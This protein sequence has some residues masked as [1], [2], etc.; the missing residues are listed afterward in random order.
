MTTDSA[1]VVP[2]V[3]PNADHADPPRHLRLRAAVLAK[4][5]PQSMRSTRFWVTR[6]RDTFRFQ[7]SGYGHGVGLCQT[8]AL[9]RARSEADRLRRYLAVSLHPT[10]PHDAAYPSVLWNALLALLY[11]TLAFGLG[12]LVY[13]ATSD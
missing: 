7:G 12:T 8:G 13:Y 2:A 6:E 4:Y 10:L 3:A 11:S 9:E 5:G 1:S